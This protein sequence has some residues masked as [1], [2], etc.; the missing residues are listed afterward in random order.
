MTATK[1][2]PFAGIT[3]LWFIGVVL[4]LSVPMYDDHGGSSVTSD[5]DESSG[6]GLLSAPPLWRR[7]VMQP[8]VARAGP[9]DA[10]IVTSG[11]R[12]QSA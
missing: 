1:L 10:C 2:M 3:F 9:N 6:C 11:R 4:A 8:M 5:A 7:T 12:R